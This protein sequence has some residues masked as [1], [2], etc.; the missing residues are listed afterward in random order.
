[1]LD[2]DVTDVTDITDTTDMTDAAAAGRSASTGPTA[3]QLRS[4]LQ[5]MSQRA[6][7][8]ELFQ[9]Q[10]QQQQFGP[11]DVSSFSR[12]PQYV[13]QNIQQQQQQLVA[14]EDRLAELQCKESLTTDEKR[15]KL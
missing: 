9:Q 3:V 14:A 4:R 10:Q 5:L 1:M 12:V 6:S 11:E 8:S 7:P 2:A 15:E 13:E